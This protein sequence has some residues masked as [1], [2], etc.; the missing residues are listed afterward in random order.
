MNAPESASRNLPSPAFH[1]P[2]TGRLSRFLFTLVLLLGSFVRVSTLAQQPSAADPTKSVSTLIEPKVW[3]SKSDYSPGSTAS[4][5]GTGF[6]PGETVGLVVNHADGTPSTGAEHQP[7]S[8]VANQAGSFQ[9][10]WHVCEDDCVGSTLLVTAVGQTSGFIAKFLF[11]DSTGFIVFS[12]SFQQGVTPTTQVTAWNGFRAQL[13]PTHDYT[14]VTMLGTFDTI[15]VSTSDPSVVSQIAAALHTL[16]A[17]TWFS[18]GRTWRVS[19]GCGGNV[20]LDADGAFCSCLFPGYNVRPGIGNSNWGGVNTATCGG[21]SQTITVIFEYEPD[22]LDQD[23]VLS[24]VDNC[25]NTYNPDQADADGDGVGDACD[26]CA[27]TP[28]P[29]Q[30]DSDG[31]GLGNACDNCPNTPGTDQT[32]GDGDGVGDACDNCPT[33]ANPDQADSD[34]GGVAYTVTRLTDTAI[35]DPDTL[36]GERLLTVCDDCW[37]YLSFEGRTFPF[38]GSS[39]DSVYVSANGHLQFPSG[40]TVGIL[41]ADLYPPSNPGGYRANLLGDRFVVTWKSLPYY[42]GGGNVTFQLTLHFGSG[43]IEMNY[44]GLD[45]SYGTLGIS[46]GGIFDTGFDFAG[47]SV[48]DSTTFGPFETIGR[49]YNPFT[50]MTDSRFRFHSGDGLGDACDPDDDND[51]ILDAQD[52]CPTVANAN[53]LDTDGDGQG[54]ACDTDDDNDGVPDVSDNCKLVANPNQEDADSD[55]LGDACDPCPN[56]SENDADHDGVCGNVDNCR[57]TPNGD[58]VDADGD[59]IGDACD[60]C[61]NTPNPDQ[62]DADG[63]G[64]GNLCDNCPFSYNPGQEDTDG[65]GVADACDNCPVVAN[66]D[67]AD[68]EG[69]GTPDSIT[70]E[71]LNTV[72][73]YASTFEF[74]L[75]GVVVASFVSDP[76]NAYNCYSSAQSFTVSDSTLL[77]AWNTTGDNAIRFRKIGSGT[78]F[79]WARARIQWG[80]FSSTRLIVDFS[81]SNGTYPYACYYYY[82]Y[83]TIVSIG[84]GGDGVGDACD[85]CPGQDD[86]QDRDGDGVPDGCDNCPNV[87]NPD[88]AD[89]DRDG[90]GDACDNCPNK[91]NPDQA[92][93]DGDGLGDACDAC[94]H[95]PANDADGDGLCGDV[96]PCPHDPANDADGDGVCGDVDNCPTVSNPPVLGYGTFTKR[97]SDPDDGSVADRISQNLAITRSNARSVYNAGSDAIEWAAG[98]CGAPTSP[99]LPDLVSL[100]RNGYLP[101]LAQLPGRDTCLH[102]ITTDKY[103][104]IHWVSWSSRGGGG[105]AYSRDG[106]VSQPDADRDGVGDACDRCPGKDDR[107]DRDG[108]TIP[109]GCDNCPNLP[110]P[111]QADYDGDGTGD[112]CDPC[113]TDKTPPTIVCPADIVKTLGYAAGH[114]KQELYFDIPGW[115]L[116]DLRGSPKFPNAPDAVRLRTSLEA[117]LFD[118]FDKYG[119]RLSGYIIA[120]TSGSYTFYLAADDQGEFW[121]ST[122]DDPANLVLVA[123][124]PEWAHRRQFTG[125]AAGGGRLGTPSP[126]GGPQQNISAPVTLVAGQAYYFEALMKEGPGNDNLAVA[127]QMPGGEAPVDFSEPIPGAYLATLSEPEC[128]QFVNF[129]PTATDDCDGTYGVGFLKQELY[130]NIP[131]WTLGYLRAAPKFPNAPDLVRQRSS[132]EANSFDEFEFY[133]TRMSGYLLPPVSGDYTFYLA[134]DDE[135]ELW[136]SSDDDPANLIQIAREPVWASRRQYWGEAGGGGRGFPQANISVPI[137]LVAGQRYYVQAL[138]KEGNFGD[139]LAVTWQMP[140]GPVPVNGDEP[141]PGQYL[142]SLKPAPTVVCNPPSGSAFPVG[143]T[144]VTCTA[145]DSSGNSSTCTFNITVMGSISGRKFY[146]ANANGTQDAGEPGISGWKI[147][148]KNAGGATATTYTDVNGD[149]LF[150]APVGSYRVAELPPRA[151]GWNLDDEN[152]CWSDRD[153]DDQVLADSKWRSTTRR[154]RRVTVSAAA[155]NQISNFGGVCVHPLANGFTLGYWSNPN[156]KAVL[157]PNDP[158]WRTLLNGCNLRN[159]NGSAYSVPGGSFS[160]AYSNFRTWLLGAKAVNMANLL[161]AQLAATTLDVQYKGLD[162]NAGLVVPACLTTSGGANVVSTLGLPIIGRPLGVRACLGTSCASGNGFITIGTLRAMAKA[163][164]LANGN[165]PAGNAARTYQESLKDL[166]DQVNNNGGLGNCPLLWMI[167][168]TACP[169]TTPY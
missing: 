168:P 121:L 118:E 15:G 11:T 36:D 34:G 66:A 19:P 47:M 45:A 38:Y 148:V 68:S 159:A 109:D 71:V 93:A 111:D 132:F 136:L 29:D 169:F 112:A 10:Q 27:N 138:M 150:N 39:Q 163:S 64:R 58:Q 115:T 3:T 99:Y 100:R 134:A 152:E 105:F 63:D 31:D 149:Y 92:N 54:D 157:T 14:K 81:G 44:D 141:I 4:I 75:N 22:D 160:T 162:D 51:G 156:G 122:D 8:V 62:A 46:T 25:P 41:L 124:E 48:G 32:D 164:L 140:G 7:W 139:H 86:R 130:F 18:D 70:F 117:N 126:N 6:Q 154:L 1:L 82:D 96:D 76:A 55:G 97:D 2:L 131:G 69:S 155:C 104:D 120:P 101:D 103:Y 89:S 80:T 151:R 129:A 90:I 74:E 16:G 79:T 137:P 144:Q 166:L 83:E 142:A 94:P 65:D 50:V 165:T 113:P 116:A 67:Q 72:F 9:S 33:V 147:A 84:R 37:T 133:G 28:N 114:V 91:P 17:G 127:W 26:N 85:R 146:D 128:S 167:S 13:T 30:A 57:Y 143:T 125:E 88:Q 110:N 119:T 135:A 23:G 60:N 95:D 78:Y 87:F 59:G 161:S 153:D 145:T 158:A 77:A 20:E 102:D 5:S 106:I 35:V 73:E 12:Q 108:D 52:N 40:A 43:E 98:T 61:P 56:D 123:R 53:Q 42:G 107:L 21:P 49:T 24:D